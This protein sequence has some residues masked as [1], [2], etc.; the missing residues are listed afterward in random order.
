MISSFYSN[1]G[2]HKKEKYWNEFATTRENTFM[3]LHIFI[4]AK[5]KTLRQRICLNNFMFNGLIVN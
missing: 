4:V 3:W 1:F 5:N 2:K